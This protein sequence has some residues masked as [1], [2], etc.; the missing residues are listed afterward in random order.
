MKHTIKFSV[1]NDLYDYIK[2]NF[3]N[4]KLDS[5]YKESETF[6]RFTCDGISLIAYFNQYLVIYL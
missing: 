5:K 1:A 6:K 4:F 3:P 2:E